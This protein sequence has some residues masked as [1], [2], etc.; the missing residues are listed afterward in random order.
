MASSALAINQSGVCCVDWINDSSEAR[1]YRRIK[2]WSIGQN[3]NYVERRMGKKGENGKLTQ[4][5]VKA[6]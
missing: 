5:F 6:H 4:F 1:R 2:I 3:K